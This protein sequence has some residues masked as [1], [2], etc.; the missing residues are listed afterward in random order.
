[1]SDVPSYQV[2]FHRGD[3]VWT[4]NG[5]A[6]QSVFELAHQANAPVETIC[7]GVGSCIRCKVKVRSG[8]LTLPT[9]LER[10]RL[11]NVFHITQE[12]LACQAKVLGD[13]SLEIP[14]PRQSRSRRSR[15]ISSSS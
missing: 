2:T 1:M 8:A 13:T 6:E 10:D 4:T 3:E 11:G 7:H 5:Q 15:F 12:R 14:Q 9:P